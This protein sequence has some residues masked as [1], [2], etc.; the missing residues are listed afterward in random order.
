MARKATERDAQ[1]GKH[2]WMKDH[3]GWRRVEVQGV[4]PSTKGI[5]VVFRDEEGQEGRR[6]LD[7]LYRSPAS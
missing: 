2:L 5:K 4:T 7:A 1:P 3:G 6:L